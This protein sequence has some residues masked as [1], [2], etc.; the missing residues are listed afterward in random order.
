MQAEQGARLVVA[1]GGD[2]TV[3]EVASGLVGMG[4]VEL[5]VIPRGTGVDFVRTFRDPDEARGRGRG[6]LRGGNAREID[7]GRVGLP[8]LVGRG[9]R[10]VVRQRRRRRDERRDREADE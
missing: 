6:R 9:R 7:A 8:R 5:A 1:V 10:G 3:N 4:G 2:G